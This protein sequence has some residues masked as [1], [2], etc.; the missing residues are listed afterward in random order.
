MMKKTI[1]ILL[2]MLL[3][4]TA[5]PFTGAFAAEDKGAAQ[6]Y[7]LG[8]TCADG[9]ILHC[10]NWTLSQ[11]KAELPDIAQAGFTSVQTS[12]LQAH[13]GRNQWYW[14]YQPNGFTIGNEL[15]S[16]SDLQALCTEADKYGIKV[17][18]DVVANHLAGSNNGTV[19]N[20]VEA[21]FKNN[22]ATYFHNKGACNDWDNREDVIM[23]NIG[24]PDLNSENTAVQN[25]VI[26]MVNQLKSAGV[27]GIR[28]DAAK[29][30]GLPS[31]NCTF[32]SNM[33]Q[34]DLYQYGEIFGNPAGD[35]GT[36]VNKNLINEYAQYIG[37]TD[38]GYS[39]D[40]TKAIKNNV[41]LKTVGNWGRQGV[42]G[43]R[44]VYWG[45]SHDTY[46]ND[47]DDGWTKNLDQN[48][49]D[50]AYAIL[51]SRADSQALYL[52]RPS[53]K[54]KT[55]IYYGKKGSTHFTSKEVAEV[56]RFHNLMVG[57]E[58]KYI[59]STSYKAVL[60]G[61]GAVLVSHSANV[62]LSV[63][64]TNAMV[65]AGTY[66]DKVSGATFTV[67]DTKITGHVGS[68]G[69]AVFYQTDQP[70]PTEPPTEP[71]TE[72]A[73]E[74]ET[75]PATEPETEPA[76]EPETEP[77]S[78]ITPIGAP[79]Y[80]VVGSFTSWGIDEA[81]KMTKNTD[82]EGDEYVFAGLDL[83]T[84]DQFKCVS[85]NA[86]IEGGDQTWYPDG[87]GNNYGEN[88]E[89][90]ADGTYDVYFRPN[91]DGDRQWYYA[92]IY[93]DGMPEPTQPEP[94]TEPAT[95]PEPETEPATDPIE[96][97]TP[98]PGEPQYYVVG[99]FTN[100]AVSEEYEMTKIAQGEKI[101]YKY[102][103]LALTTADQFKVV[104]VNY[105]I[106]GAPQTWYPDGM[107]NNYGEN[108]E[109]TAEGTYDVYFDPAIATDG[110]FYNCIFVDGM[111]VPTQAP[112][113][114]PTGEAPTY[115]VMKPIAMLPNA[116]DVTA[117][118][119]TFTVYF[120][121]PNG[122][123]S[124]IPTWENEFNELDGVNYAGI[125]WWQGDPNLNPWPGAKM[126]LVDAE[127][128]IFSANVPYEPDVLTTIIFN[129]AIDGGTDKTAEVYSAAHQTA[130]INCQG[131]EA[132]DSNTMPEGTPA[133]N[134][135]GCIFICDPATYSV[136]QFSGK[137]TV[138]GDWY[139]YYGDGHYGF[140]A[141]D[142]ENFVSVE[143]NCM[144]PN[145]DHGHEIPSEDPSEKPSE[146][147]SAM[148]YYIVGNMTGWAV[149]EAY[150]MTPDAD[151][152]HY[153]YTMDLTTESQFKVV[154]VD[155]E[156]NQTWLP[157]GM[158]N[159]YGENGEITE[160]GTYDITFRAKPDGGEEWF[161]GIIKVEKVEASEAILGDVDG[162]GEVTI[163]DATYIQR[164]ATNLSV[165]F[166]E[167]QMLKVDVD[168][169]GEV[170]IVE[171]TFVQRYATRVAVPYPIGEKIA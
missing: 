149:D 13:D 129:N 15:G 144:N 34:I 96:T 28:W 120:Q 152:F 98:E 80:Y 107:G 162:D 32:W 110:W 159:N 24:M 7:G 139:V 168:G 142:S 163:V 108:G 92:C 136:N 106:E 95:E 25:K 134:F 132:G 8:Q 51:G 73:T 84:T 60:R 153:T 166:T 83:T 123:N 71:A 12:P 20:S 74:P 145:H 100:W 41:T 86:S 21:E 104:S 63:N 171:A 9:N 59:S 36:T 46:A 62:D 38:S 111:P 47:G 27:D 77:A 70:E 99:S 75:E 157:D 93:V 44:I 126:T 35:S 14:L 48:L 33:A 170:T 85:F 118:V 164:Y 81:Y 23:K 64:N 124:E 146:T 141:E 133:D 167:A 158:G 52:S 66:T 116:D 147:P 105:S 154:G 54:N 53:E 113:E 58:E 49:I 43:D 91:G 143:E 19:A 37:V 82:A 56:N 30:I 65:P 119:D 117:E 101:L 29:H 169:D 39:G 5:V 115:P 131:Y 122:S 26:T 61:G 76:T 11:I 138:D 137:D 160:D 42:A 130:N 156:G 150:K 1:A 103:D 114:E 57:T 55:S 125:Y 109:I 68:T 102:D 94:E 148:D 2:A 89:I 17:I 72:P 69:I 45:E 78:E 22:K 135:D 128:G 90:T 112:T 79:E 97:V 165:P 31:E 10:F 6:D 121:M 155:G 67:T 87:M 50:K 151:N 18:V 140:Y 3:I 88:G 40:I 4:L 16:Y 127:Q 161:Y